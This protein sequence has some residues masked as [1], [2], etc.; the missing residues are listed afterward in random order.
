MIKTPER[1]PYNKT[2]KQLDA[3]K[4]KSKAKPGMHPDGEGLYLR[5]SKAG[6]KSWAL[7]FMMDKK[8]TEMG[9]DYSGNIS[10]QDLIT[11]IKSE[12]K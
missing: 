5:I 8:A 9:L 12:T 2:P 11:L 7:R 6:S 1:S 3:R 10:K 4:V